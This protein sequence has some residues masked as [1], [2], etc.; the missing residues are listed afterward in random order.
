MNRP[1][2]T[3]LETWHLFKSYSEVPIS[4]SPQA[5]YRT[6]WVHTVIPSIKSSPPSVLVLTF[7]PFLVLKESKLLGAGTGIPPSE[8]ELIL[9]RNGAENALGEIL[10]AEPDAA[11]PS[12]ALLVKF[13]DFSS[14]KAGKSSHSWSCERGIQQI[15]AYD[16]GWVVLYDD[17][18]VATLGDPRFSDCLGREVT[19]GGYVAFGLPIYFIWWNLLTMLCQSRRGAW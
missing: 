1:L 16:A 15:A 12:G 17:G 14:R 11:A 6:R 10:A 3:N 5:D 19:E 13:P 18:T 7:Y 4:R 9:D 8:K 2:E